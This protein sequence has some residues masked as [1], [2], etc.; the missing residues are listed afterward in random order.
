MYISEVSGHH[1]ATL[2]IEKAIRILTPHAEISNINAFNYT[3]PVA[4]KV[5][6]SVYMSIIK[7]AP[8]IWDYL[9]DNPKIVKKIE[10]AKQN[11]N[12]AN[13]PKLKKLF[14]RLKPEVV[15]CTQAFPCGMV[16]GYKKTYQAD[17]PLIAVLTDY[18]PHSYWIYDA[19]DCYITPSE[20]VSSRLIKK[21]VPA[22]KVKS[23]G[24][25]FDP[26]FNTTLDKNSIFSKYKLSPGLPTILIMG[27][28]QGLGPIKTIVKSLEKIDRD[29]QEIIVTGTNK[30]LYNSLRRK[31]KKYKKKIVVFG[32][33]QNIN[34]LMSI[35]DIVVSKPGGVTT[36]EVLSLAKP[37]IIVKPLPG[38]E[39]NNTA[40]LTQKEAALEIEEPGKI[41]L[42][43]E[44]L[45]RNHEKLKHLS[46]CAKR[47]SKPN[48]SMDIARL[49]LE[50][51][52]G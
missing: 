25:P 38:Q 44:D 47:I 33:A 32:Y 50:S 15:V 43:I 24:I 26:K 14:E 28:G 19:V 37:M 30:K 46:D 22:Q 21:G 52:N 2:A 11:I 45:L 16:A 51:R 27:G 48:A 41:N 23:L 40:Y 6:N 17:L 39:A 49:L 20:D 7:V 34:E 10:K 35:A 29:I 12:K 8:K 9:Y 31:I 36:S 42:V 5:V 13:S 4:E 3:N 1:N 18:V